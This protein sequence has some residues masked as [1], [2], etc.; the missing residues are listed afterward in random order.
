MKPVIHACLIFLALLA[1]AR[2]TQV[3]FPEVMY[4]PTS[5]KPEF[6]EVWNITRTPL[7]MGRWRFTEGVDYTFPDFTSGQAHILQPFER[8]LISAADDAST[9]AAYSSIPSN[10]RILGPWT[11]SLDNNGE[12]VTLTDKNG[13][14]LCTL[15]YDNHLPWPLAADGTGHSIVLIN[16]NTNLENPRNWR[17]SYLRHG[18][19][20]KVDTSQTQLY[21]SWCRWPVRGSTTT[22]STR[23]PR[24]GTRPPSMRLAGAGHH[25]RCS[26]SRR[27]RCRRPAS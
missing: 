2:A 14:I 20:G 3:V 22:G 15:R 11:G 5:G 9:R 26:A 13:V 16:E 1:N 7:D 8:I 17:Q 25:S 6:I 21:T 12:R 18:S 24:T 10:V 19:P 4:R 23:P 27:H